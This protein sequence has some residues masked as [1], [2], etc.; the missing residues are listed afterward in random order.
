L[1]TDQILLKELDDTDYMYILEKGKLQVFTEFEGNQFDIDFLN[2]GSVLGQRAI[3][4]EDNM[5]VNIR[6]VQPSYLCMIHE[7]EFT[8][9]QESFPVFDK[10]LKFY[11][12]RMYMDEKIYPLDYIIH[13]H[14]GKEKI[15]RRN[16]LK[17]IVALMIQDVRALKRKPKLKDVLKAFEGKDKNFVAKKLI[18][19]YSV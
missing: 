10:Y 7:D 14:H 9:I 5:V 18:S 17:N 1:E 11:Q 13:V 12:N 8:K 19:M 16:I 6:A 2:P 15:K 4:T 3:F